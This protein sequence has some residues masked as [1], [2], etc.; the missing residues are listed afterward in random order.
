MLFLKNN[1]IF[2]EQLPTIEYY[3]QVS[4]KN[5]IMTFN[6]FRVSSSPIDKWSQL[7]DFYRKTIE[8]HPNIQ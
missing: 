7:E 3:L 5:I 4:Y 8:I 2:S 6:I 1:A